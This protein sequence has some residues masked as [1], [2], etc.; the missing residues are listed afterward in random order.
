MNLK[1]T[2]TTGDFG[3]RSIST[4]LVQISSIAMNSNPEALPSLTLDAFNSGELTRKPVSETRWWADRCLPETREK[5]SL[6]AAKW[7]RPG[8]GTQRV[9]V[10]DRCFIV[11]RQATTQPP[12]GFSSALTERAV[13]CCR[14]N[15]AC[16]IQPGPD[17]GPGLK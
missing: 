9:F 13:C 4:I 1:E 3:K 8:R 11:Y 2:Q 17:S 10:A 5:R 6:E 12:R 15:P 7:W 16:I 14:E